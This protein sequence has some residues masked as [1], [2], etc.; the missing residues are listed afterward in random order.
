M[1]IQFKGEKMK[2]KRYFIISIVVAL[3]ILALLAT[4]F[5]VPAMP[6]MVKMLMTT[7]YLI[8]LTVTV[9][10][11]GLAFSPLFFGPLSDRF[12]RRPVLLLCAGL[13]L[14]GTLL[15]W[16]APIA[17]VLIVGRLLQGIGL[18]GALSLAR[19]IGS[20]L[21]NKE[22]FAK[23]AGVLALFVSI[24]PA[25]A[26][27][28]GSYLHVNFGWRS[29][30]LLMSILVG[31]CFIAVMKNVPE[32]NANCD[33][34]A[35]HIRDML[36][37][38]RE[39]LT[40][41][42]F[43]C[44]TI[45]AGLTISVLILFGVLSTF[46]FQNVYHLTSTQYGWIMMIVSSSTVISRMFNIYLLRSRS[47][48]QCINIGLWF[49]L[50]GSI[51]AISMSLLQ[52]HF[53]MSIIVPATLIIFGAGIVPSNTVAI[54]LGPFRHIGGSAGAIYGCITMLSVF[55][56]SFA[57]TFLPAADLVLAIVFLT[58]SLLSWAMIK[59]I[60]TSEAAFLETTTD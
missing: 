3:A 14:V 53:I 42:I 11:L 60:P 41:R 31:I 58:I 15:C 1:I 30:F 5:Y 25:I 39:L 50:V 17:H 4:D 46:I 34:N 45:L 22:E 13:G 23:V 12:G 27:V 28:I 47:P 57:G 6:D 55:V 20:D 40:H 29:I 49:M 18:G 44:T 7:H 19:T 48:E 38:Y 8:K 35:L 24:G 43:M 26:P 56:V 54:A 2:D 59:L 9:F 21:F 52:Q 10:M 33:I 51:A 32:T 37:H 16:L 36:K